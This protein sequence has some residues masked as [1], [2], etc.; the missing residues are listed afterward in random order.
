MIA[1]YAGM[2]LGDLDSSALPAPTLPHSPFHCLT[3]CF[4]SG[5]IDEVLE[6]LF[7]SQELVNFLVMVVGIDDTTKRYSSYGCA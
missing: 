1:D 6:C 3:L 7:M 4:Y 2:T 5:A